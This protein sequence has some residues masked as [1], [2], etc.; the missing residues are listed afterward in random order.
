[1]DELL[2]ALAGLILNAQVGATGPDAIA[3]RLVSDHYNGTVGLLAFDKSEFRRTSVKGK[4][5]VVAFSGFGDVVG[6]ILNRRGTV[7]CELSGYYDGECV[8]LTGCG[9]SGVAC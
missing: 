7:L 8:V 9:A 3:S 1:M 4:H 6:V 5:S 2:N